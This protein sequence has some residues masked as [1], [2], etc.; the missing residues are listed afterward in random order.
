MATPLTQ[1]SRPSYA[2]HVSR[3]R[4]GVKHIG[5][6]QQ[7]S[8]DWHPTSFIPHNGTVNPRSSSLNQRSKWNMACSHTPHRTVIPVVSCLTS[9]SWHEICLTI[10]LFFS[11]SDNSR[12]CFHVY[13]HRVLLESVDRDGLLIWTLL[14]KSLISGAE[15]VHKLKTTRNPQLLQMSFVMC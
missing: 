5:S 3:T 7:R 8:I 13:F 1:C 9:H 6:K 4:A 2:C 15:K 10:N 12:I 14:T 11:F